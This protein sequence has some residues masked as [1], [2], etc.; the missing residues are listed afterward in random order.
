M[1]N[2]ILLSGLKSVMIELIIWKNLFIIEHLMKRKNL[3]YTK[4]VDI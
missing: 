4:E 2:L 3:F 1:I